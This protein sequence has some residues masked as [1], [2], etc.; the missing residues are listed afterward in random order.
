MDW[1]RGR[2]KWCYERMQ[3][4]FIVPFFILQVIFMA[5]YDGSIRIN[6]EIQTKQAQINLSTLENRIV[7]T[8]DKIASLRSKMDALKDAK[9]PTQDY[10]NLQKEIDK[11]T[12]ELEKMV[13]QDSK[14]ADIDAKIKSLS[15]SSAE[16]AAKMKEVAEQKIPTKE[17]AAAQKEVDKYSDTLQKA[18]EK[19]DKLLEIGVDKSSSRFKSAQYDV[20][21]LEN[22]LLDAE[23]VVKRL[24][25]EGKA[26][27][28]GIDT[29][30]YK[31]LSVK[32][33]QVNAE[34]EKQKGIHSE[35][36]QKQAD[37]V[38]KTIELKAQI[39]QLVEEG[40]D[41]TLGSSTE[42][43]AK[44]GQQLQYAENDLEVLNQKHEVLELKQEK[45]AEGYKR[46]GDIAKKSF[47]SMGKALTKVNSYVN[48]FGKRI[49]NITQKILPT[50]HK[51][52]KRTNTVL[53]QFSTRL[54]SLLSGIFI[55]N[56]ISSNMRKMFSGINEGFENFYNQNSVF[57]S[58]VDNM[59]VSLLQLKNS[60]A[61]AF[62]PIVS[63]AIPYLEKLIS[64]I[65]KAVN[66][67]GQLI[68]ALLGKK[69][70]TRA[71]RTSVGGLEDTADAF[72]EVKESAKDAEK[73]IEGYLSPLDEINK[74]SEDKEVKIDIDTGKK[75]D[76]SDIGDTI[77]DMFE[78][79][80]IDSYFL[81]LANKVKDIFSQL[82]A[83]L[84]EAW[85]REGK[86]VMDSWKYALG[87][88][89]DLIKS[90]GSDFLEVWQQEKTIK[91]FEDLLH[92]IGDIGL[93]VGN[94]AHNFRL[95]W[96]ENETGKRILEGIRDIIGVIVA[97]IRHA[98]DVTVEWSKNLNFAPLLTKVQGWIESLVP[99]FDNLSGIITDF[100]EKV[101]LPLGKWTIEKGLP[102]LLQVF[103]DFNNK[104]DW[105]ALRSRLAQ[106][107]E[108][109][110]PFA[111]T[112][113]EGLII[114]IERCANALADFINSPAFDNF[115]TMIENWMDSVKPE[116]VADALEAIA[117]SIIALK[118]AVVGFSAISKGITALSSLINVLKFFG[119]GGG[120]SKV[121]SGLK[122]IGSVGVSSIKKLGEALSLWK[123]GAGTLSESLSAMFPT[124]SKIVSW[125]P[126]AAI[127]A[128]IVGVGNEIKKQ[129]QNLFNTEDWGISDWIVNTL[130]TS[131]S[132]WK[133]EFDNFKIS[134]EL[135]WQDTWMADTIWKFGQW[136][137]EKVK[138]WF[139]SEKWSELWET[140]KQ[141]AL[142]KWEE[143]K[144][145]I[146]TKIEEIKINISTKM[147]EIKTSLLTAWNNIKT[148]ILSTWENLKQ[149]A[150]NI[151]NNISQFFSDTWN[152]ITTTISET[153]ENITTFLQ[154]K[155]EHIKET[156]VTIFTNIRDFL[157]ETWENIKERISE[158]WENIKEK[159]TT[160]IQAVK[161][162]ITD[163]MTSA[164]ETWSSAWDAMKEK[165]SSIIE[166]VKNTIQSAFDWIAEKVSA[167]AEKLS[168]VG[169]KAKSLFSRGTSFFSG[170][171]FGGSSFSVS[172]YS[173]ASPAMQAL[174]NADIPGYASGQVIPATMKKH[175][176]YLGDNNHE[177]EVVSPLSTI[178]QAVE[179]VMARI[180]GSG[181]IENKELT[182][183]IPVIIDGKQITEIVLNNAMIKQMSTGNNP[184][185]LGNT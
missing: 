172:S 98:A 129:M 126:H 9:I 65:T 35:I 118:V 19:I 55:F 108:H 131:L 43:F 51:E 143:I 120:A 93:V 77:E 112:V 41:F 74:Y 3:C 171:L 53:G 79:V 152:S 180:N 14:L 22:K 69:T 88:V 183:K 10:Q 44:L 39:N 56:V 170:G 157:M 110:E 147:E 122:S 84:K 96:E 80:P 123:G 154:E 162:K 124:A 20:A 8:S 178:E 83:P 75:P 78:E 7:K 34:L 148:Y 42:E 11:A 177:T 73:A 62:A 185:L 46:L 165:V 115:L 25:Q 103:I 81:D 50:F 52:T 168:S 149:G 5:Q 4:A 13:A 101:L 71:I 106:F 138:P 114:F 176:A 89:W 182:I 119:A 92:I 127:A 142:T 109:L 45:A 95:A 104:V 161:D 66:S 155:W 58:S 91:I 160:A 153:W 169:S 16:Y 54:K 133:S 125:I 140:V 37:A 94:L 27:T 47:D 181:G 132:G 68:A 173:F 87:E 99:V 17:Y 151:W 158:V 175:L 105:E 139:T 60:L 128:A 28:L 49:K 86:F 156:V 12:Q 121:I 30:Q 113:G 24:E 36:A 167:I 184:F 82:F 6:T 61:A 179:N 72:E 146:T 40:K 15:Q 32:Y 57:K 48:S 136:W 67:I 102:E 164:K 116:D 23:E 85:N 100:Y 145:T 29:D 159:V 134:L 18:K 107:W 63:V 144:T 33:G 163:V 26:F 21:Q 31:N 174:S 137:N 70:Y 64:Y 2:A 90:I 38:Q 59:R 150:I 1:H 97:N 76:A 135:W 141:S 130:K 117:K 166:G 111:E